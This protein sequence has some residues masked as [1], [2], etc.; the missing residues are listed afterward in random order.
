MVSPLIIVVVIGLTLISFNRQFNVKMLVEYEENFAC[1]VSCC[2]QETQ[3][4]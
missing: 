4:P 1:G 2:G 3:D